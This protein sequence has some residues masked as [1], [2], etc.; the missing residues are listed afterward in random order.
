M[1]L[2][3]SK[4][5][6]A[7]YKPPFKFDYGYIF[8]STGKV[9]AD[10]NIQNDGVVHDESHNLIL[11]VRGWGHIQKIKGE[12]KPEDIQDEIGRLIAEGL[13]KYWEEEMKKDG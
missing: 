4:A 5:A 13:T 11:R 7:V 2:S 12:H 10:N 9:V 6:L 8:D 1:K 3:L